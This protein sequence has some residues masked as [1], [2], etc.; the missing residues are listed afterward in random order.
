M[1]TA[2]EGSGAILTARKLPLLATLCLPTYYLYTPL[3][4]TRHPSRQGGGLAG[5]RVT[6]SPVQST[7][8]AHGL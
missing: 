8:P 2:D 5:R 4:T 7:A 1:C 6:H 3:L